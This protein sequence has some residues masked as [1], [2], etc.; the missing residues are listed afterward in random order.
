M[1]AWETDGD[2]TVTSPRATPRVRARDL[3]AAFGGSVTFDHAVGYY[4][5]TRGLSPEV[6]AE[7]AR[8]LGGELAP[9]SRV[10]EVG[11][12][13]GQITIPLVR[14]GIDVVGL[15]LSEPMLE[16]LDEKAREGGVSLPLVA[17]DA[18]H[19]PI[20]DA[21]FDAVVM[22]HVLHLVADW[23]GAVAEVVRIVRP[24]GSF[25][26]SITDYTGLYRTL[27]ERFLEAAGGLPIALGLRPDDPASLERVMA[28]HGAAGRVL[29]AIRGRRT[30][31]VS[32][33]LR[34]MERGV[35]TWTWAASR[36]ERRD[37]VRQVRRWA[38]EHVGRL[39]RPVEPEFEIEWRAF[40]LPA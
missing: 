3:L 29:P 6:R 19:L 28:Q 36:T 14:A 31:T 9:G 27:Q 37:A 2:G 35:Y 13:T 21:S 32:A 24:G 18:T 12:G 16:R 39:D 4:D 38:R 40:R 26:V 17:G 11:A 30:L 34:N 7:T 20:A 33:F 15:D 10:V 8:L 23:R 1:N 25:L 5:E 22:R